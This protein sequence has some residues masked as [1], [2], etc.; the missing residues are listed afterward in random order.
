VEPVYL[1]YLMSLH[2]QFPLRLPLPLWFSL[3]LLLFPNASAFTE[4]YDLP[5]YSTA[6]DCVQKCASSASLFGVSSFLCYEDFPATCLCNRLVGQ[7]SEIASFASACAFTS[8][9]NPV[10]VTKAQNIW[11]DYC[12]VNDAV[13]PSATEASTEPATAAGTRKWISMPI[14]LSRM[15]FVWL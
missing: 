13:L 8:C 1:I 7:S 5:S 3:S 10:D 15:L 12:R 6:R 14:V 2:L 9:I 11:A 4:I